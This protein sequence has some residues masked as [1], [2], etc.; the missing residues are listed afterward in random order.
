MNNFKSLFRFSRSEKVGSMV[1]AIIIV[2]LMVWNWLLDIIPADRK[3]NYDEFEQE[4][5]AFKENL[6]FI[7]DV[8]EYE[9]QQ[10]VKAR[11]ADIELFEFNP[12]IADSVTLNKLGFTS[13]QIKI[14]LNYRNKGGRF[15]RTSDLA[16][17]YGISI[18]QYEILEPFIRLKNNRTYK[19]TENKGDNKLTPF[20]F[21][22]NTIKF[23]DLQRLGLSNQQAEN[24]VNY[25]KAGGKFYSKKDVAKIY[26]I[27]EDE[28]LQLSPYIDIATQ[29]DIQETNEE[30]KRIEIEINSATTQELTKLYGIGNTLAKRIVKYRKLLGGFYS[31][32]QLNEVYGLKPETIKNI[33]QNIVFETD[34]IRKI[35]INFA[36]ERDLSKHIYINYELAEKIVEYRTKKG[37]YNSIE[38]LINEN[39]TDRKTFEKIKH[40]I[41]TN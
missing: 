31:I 13:G 24:I 15:Y 17:I 26:S 20:K 30:V 22:P 7:E 28:Y 9:A 38:T 4:L 10:K 36:S 1:L 39:I 37:S 34:R 5:I 8:E 41:T 18:T 25:R 29:T 23:E 14:I 11:Y 32:A 35:N 19:K 27:S 21:D 2:I 12:N 40:Y 3:Y 6:Q 33:E 16:K